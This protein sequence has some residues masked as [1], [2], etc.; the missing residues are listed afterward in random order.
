MALNIQ[1][2]QKT[3]VVTLGFIQRGVVVVVVVVVVVL[4]EGSLVM[5]FVPFYYLQNLISYT[6][7]MDLNEITL[8]QKCIV[9]S[10]I[11]FQFTIWELRFGV[12]ITGR[13]RDRMIADHSWSYQQL[14]FSTIPISI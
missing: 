7:K 1:R 3:S 9:Y 2:L 8:S 14:N 11:L 10:C 12:F 4:A 5:T 13:F 6:L